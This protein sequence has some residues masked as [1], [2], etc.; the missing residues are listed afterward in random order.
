MSNES[1]HWVVSPT[2]PSLCPVPHATSSVLHH[3]CLEQPWCKNHQQISTALVVHIP[4]SQFFK[5]LCSHTHTYIKCVV[6]G[7]HLCLYFMPEELAALLVAVRM[8]SPSHCLH[9]T[10]CSF[11]AGQW[12]VFQT[13]EIQREQKYMG[14]S[15]C[16]VQSR[17]RRKA[18]NR[19]KL[20][21][22]NLL[23]SKN[24]KTLVVEKKAEAWCSFLLLSCCKC[25]SS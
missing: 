20:P 17:K 13:D 16:F 24:W 23:P 2:A 5:H 12:C 25:F 19:A 6:S 15:H 11:R 1:L 10:L 21:V 8:T 9:C 18:E 7:G 3:P 4:K 14:L 22:V